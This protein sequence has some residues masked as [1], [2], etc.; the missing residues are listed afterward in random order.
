MSLINVTLKMNHTENFLIRFC[1]G[2]PYR[3]WLI[4]VRQSEGCYLQTDRQTDRINSL[5]V[6]THLARG[7]P[8]AVLH[9]YQRT[10]RKFWCRVPEDC[11]ETKN[12]VKIYTDECLIICS[13]FLIIAVW[14]YICV[15]KSSNLKLSITGMH[16]SLAKQDKFLLTE[17]IT[18][19]LPDHP[20]FNCLRSSLLQNLKAA[21]SSRN[22][23]IT[24]WDTDLE[25]LNWYL[26][27][28][29]FCCQCCQLTDL[30]IYTLISLI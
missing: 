23:R 1:L 14:P 11:A 9:L 12:I 10:E 8:D 30:P 26:S 4:L 2:L 15:G 29:Q 16:R 6:E 13:F 19:G 21:Q 24:T 17:F 27:K 20:T 28:Q 25:N 3:V 5:V 22:F 7:V 18:H